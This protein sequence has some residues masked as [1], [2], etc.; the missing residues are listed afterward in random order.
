VLAYGPV[1]GLDHARKAVQ[2]AQ[3]G[4]DNFDKGVGGKLLA[5][6]ETTLKDV[7]E[8]DEVSNTE[9]VTGEDGEGA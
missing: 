3:W 7:L 5:I 6:A 8:N 9:E 2:S 4:L 1:N